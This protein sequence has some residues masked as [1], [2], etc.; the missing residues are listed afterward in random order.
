MTFGLGD[1][2][3]VKDVHGETISGVITKIYANSILVWSQTT[4][5]LVCKKEI[6]QKGGQLD[7]ASDLIIGDGQFTISKFRSA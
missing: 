3:T 2:I 7:E 1:K 4:P 5:H 6:Y